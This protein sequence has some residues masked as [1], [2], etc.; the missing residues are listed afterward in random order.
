[1]RNSGGRRCVRGKE[2]RGVYLGSTR[3][4]GCY[5]LAE[6]EARCMTGYAG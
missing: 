1:M 4:L 3:T 6:P 5:A 2:R